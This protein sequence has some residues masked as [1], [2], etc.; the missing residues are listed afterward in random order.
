MRDRRLGEPDEG[1]Q[2]GV[3]A[4]HPLLRAL[5]GAHRGVGDHDV[6]PAELLHGRLDERRDRSL[7]GDVERGGVDGDA[8]GA[9]LFGGFLERRLPAG[10]EHEVD[11]LLGELDAIALPSPRLAPVTMALRPESPSSMGMPF[12]GARGSSAVHTL[13]S[14]PQ[15]S[16]PG[17]EFG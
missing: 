14:D 15:V 3:E 17:E 11:A 16:K 2:V 7:V 13:C 1:E 4:G 8:L 5:L 10:A 6:Q 12:L 9:E